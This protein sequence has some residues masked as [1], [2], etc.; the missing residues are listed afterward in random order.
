MGTKKEKIPYKDKG[1]RGKSQDRVSI[2]SQI[3]QVVGGVGWIAF[4]LGL[5]LAGGAADTMAPWEEI[6]RPFLFGVSV[7]GIG[8]VLSIVADR[9]GTE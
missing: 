4:I 2:R 1:S 6:A 3:V 7:A 8:M 9:I 5:Y